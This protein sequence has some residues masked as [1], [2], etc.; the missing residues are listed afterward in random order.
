[1]A[2]EVI[3]ALEE[4]IA[5][6]SLLKHSFYQAWT[7]GE[8]PIE[9]LRN[10]AVQYYPHVAAFPRYLSAIHSRCADIVTRQALLENLIEEERGA[11]NHPELWL[12]FAEA[13]GVPRAS[14][15]VPAASPAVENL[16]RTYTELCA[17]GRPVAGLSALYVYEAQI[18][19][20][21]SAKIDGLKRFY[22]ITDDRGV[23]FF[24]VH[25]QADRWHSETDADLIER[26]CDGDAD[27]SASAIESGR[28]ALDALWSA[29]DSM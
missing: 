23:A 12:R 4:M 18:P 16:V 28:R 22:G 9:R 17:N 13:L 26:Y 11:E 24:S 25:E 3:A 29:L 5:A 15:L 7:A 21:A 27:V 10:Y 1:M 20:I 8:L 14:V 19:A 6:R 2:R